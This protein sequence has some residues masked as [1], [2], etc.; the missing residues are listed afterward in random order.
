MLFLADALLK[1]KVHKEV[2][3]PLDHRMDVV[4]D[5]LNIFK[6]SI[7]HDIVPIEDVYGPTGWDPDIQGLVVSKETLSGAGSSA[8]L[9]PSMTCM[10][11]HSSGMSSDFL[12]EEYRKEKGFPSLRLF[13]IDVISSSSESIDDSD[14][15]VMK[16][17][18]MSSTFIRE[19]V[20]TR[21]ETLS[22]T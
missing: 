22:G 16:N 17:T 21:G 6:P 3:E 9:I 11:S 15:T 19:W 13:V 2:L 12:V 1:N 8:S 18:K 7:T 5:F 4:R 20:V 10:Q 14:M